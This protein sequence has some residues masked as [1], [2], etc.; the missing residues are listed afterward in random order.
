[1]VEPS[2]V[3]VPL[4]REQIFVGRLPIH[5]EAA[6]AHLPPVV[7]IVPVGQSRLVAIKI[8]SV[9]TEKCCVIDLAADPIALVILDAQSREVIDRW[10]ALEVYLLHSRMM[11]LRIANRQ[12][13]SGARLAVAGIND[14]RSALNLLPQLAQR[15]RS[16]GCKDGRESKQR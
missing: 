12:K 1:L 9:D 2:S 7:R 14:M 11:E 6:T 4:Q 15:Q 10:P 3:E 8:L 16:D 13:P 5:A